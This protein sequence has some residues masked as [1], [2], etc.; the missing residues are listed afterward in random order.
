MAPVADKYLIGHSVSVKSL[1]ETNVQTSWSFE[2]G[3]NYSL[4]PFSLDF[5]FFMI[6][7]NFD[8]TAKKLISFSTGYIILLF[9][10]AYF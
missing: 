3:S 7:L 6:S 1:R 4:M 8:K 5:G 2:S 9:L 10:T